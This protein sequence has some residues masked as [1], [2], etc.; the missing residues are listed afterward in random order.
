MLCR[1]NFDFLPTT[2][3]LLLPLCVHMHT[4]HLPCSGNGNVLIGTV[5]VDVAA[6]IWGLSE[7]EKAVYA[8]QHYACERVLHVRP[9]YPYLVFFL[10]D[11]KGTTPCHLQHYRH[12]LLSCLAVL[13]VIKFYVRAQSPF[14]VSDKASANFG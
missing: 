7:E 11:K 3:I 6:G 13:P 2:Q 5:F 1:I 4:P 14:S 9:R 8:F 10:L 12:D